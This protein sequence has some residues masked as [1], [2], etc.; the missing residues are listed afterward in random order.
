[1]RKT[2]FL[3]VLMFPLALLACEGAGDADMEATEGVAEG[4]AMVD[5][6]T[7]QA[8]L[9]R[10]RQEWIR[11]AEAGDAAGIANLYATD[12]VFVGTGGD[13]YVGRQAI[14]GAFAPGLE[15]MT[16]LDIGNTH[17]TSGTDMISGVGTFSQTVQTDQGEQTVE[18]HYV[19]VAER[20]EDGS[21]KIV[22][23]ISSAPTQA[24][25]DSV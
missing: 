14:Q 8:E 21:W 25:G 19:V 15:G 22:Q 6:A 2:R 17:T 23:H 13:V 18:G 5:E 7:M 9:D 11:L 10:L 1:M 12:A 3:P 20:Q 24:P 4:A 16:N